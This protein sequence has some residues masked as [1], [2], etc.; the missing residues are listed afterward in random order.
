MLTFDKVY[1]LAIAII[2]G[3]AG[4][5]WSFW[6]FRK[7]HETG[8]FEKAVIGY[9]LGLVLVPFLFLL[10]YLATILYNPIFIYINWL[11][12][13]V[14]GLYFAYKD[15]AYKIDVDFSGIFNQ[16]TLCLLALFAI[17]FSSFIIAFS[18]SGIPIMDLDPY[19]Y[20]DGV[21]QVVYTG[22]NMANDMT[23]WYPEPISSHIGNPI[24]KYMMASWYSLYNGA[25]A[26][27]PYTLMGV[28]SIYPP[29]IG[30]LA[31][32]FAY[33]ALK[34]LYNHRSGLLAAGALAF[35]PILML[36]FQGGDFQI[37]PYNV[38]AFVFLM[39]A[40]AYALRKNTRESSLFLLAATA[41][42]F[43]GSNL[44]S[45]VLFVFSLAVFC[46]CI[47]R[48]IHDTHEGEK[49][50]KTIA[51]FIGAIILCEALFLAYYVKSGADVG[52][53]AKTILPYILIPLA[54][55]ACALE[56]GLS[57]TVTFAVVVPAMVKVHAIIG[58]AEA[59]I[60]I[61]LVKTFRSFLPK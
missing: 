10:E 43:L 26:Y 9:T 40:F 8:I 51:H 7:D 24:W 60:T 30:A 25:A 1:A 3:I 2:Y 13:L 56:L 5:P 53:S 39:G 33:F 52:G 20:L 38:F 54:A 61:A 23:A 59:L 15:K 48:F 31:A 19:F 55:F 47:A 42:S 36:K 12:V 18:V 41:C 27:S 58:I 46:I 17:M 49:R 28:G 21:R 35:M 22:Q 29:I 37:E 57:G 32:F 6:L 34:Q 45:L 50:E 16:R 4:I 14:S 44:A 11:A